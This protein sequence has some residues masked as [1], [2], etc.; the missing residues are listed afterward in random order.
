VLASAGRLAQTLG[1][2]LTLFRVIDIFSV[3]GRGAVLA[4]TLESG[5]LATGDRLQLK[6]PLG[7]IE[8]VARGLE[9]NRKVIARARVGE[10]IAILTG[11]LD[12]ES[13]SDGF[14]EDAE[15]TRR[16]VALT[17]R[18]SNKSWWEFWR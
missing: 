17:I 15:G 11:P 18:D 7:S 3:P 14:K 10:S 8:V 13:V 4:G 1:L 5:E 2:A 12:L 16:V 9:R 6:S